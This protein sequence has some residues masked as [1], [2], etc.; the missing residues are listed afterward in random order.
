MEYKNCICCGNPIE[1][2]DEDCFC[3]DCNDSFDDVG[4]NKILKIVIIVGISTIL[5]KIFL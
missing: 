3:D 4:G 5:L 2:F 1:D